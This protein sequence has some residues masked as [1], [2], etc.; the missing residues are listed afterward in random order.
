MLKVSNLGLIEERKGDERIVIHSFR[1]TRITELAMSG[2][3]LKVAMD[4]T[5]HSQ[6]STHLD[7]TH[8]SGESRGDLVRRLAGGEPPA[9]TD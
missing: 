1:H 8:P 6:L 7:Y 9:K 3:P 2:V 5:G 4:E